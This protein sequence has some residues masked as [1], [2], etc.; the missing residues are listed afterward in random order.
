MF[1]EKCNKLFSAK[2]YEYNYDSYRF[3]AV[4]GECSLNKVKVVL[5][6]DE[7]FKLPNRCV[8]LL[9]LISRKARPKLVLIALA[10]CQNRLPFYSLKALKLL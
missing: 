3:V 7:L 4:G 6:T 5:K 2:N 1:K 10:V 9:T 8:D